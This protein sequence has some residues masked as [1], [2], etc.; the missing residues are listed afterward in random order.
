MSFD[1]Y[2]EYR[3]IFLKYDI[4]DK[5]FKK[6]HFNSVIIVSWFNQQIKTKKVSNIYFLNKFIWIIQWK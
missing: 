1:L 5:E 2:S 3:L 4:L 6:E